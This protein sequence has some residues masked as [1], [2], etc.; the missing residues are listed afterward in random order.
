M[1]HPMYLQRTAQKSRSIIFPL[2]CGNT[3]VI[4][5]PSANDP[6][7]PVLRR[8]IG[9]TL[10]VRRNIG[11]I[12]IVDLRIMVG[13][14]TDVTGQSLPNRP[15]TTLDPVVVTVHAVDVNAEAT[16]RTRAD[17]DPALLRGVAVRTVIVRRVPQRLLAVV[18]SLRGILDM[19][20]QFLC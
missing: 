8:N 7:L 9:V 11:V 12:L 15:L 16:P 3:P 19:V 18:L 10:I 20:G 13:D 1:R 4:P 2:L 14:E 5:R 17:P 6:L